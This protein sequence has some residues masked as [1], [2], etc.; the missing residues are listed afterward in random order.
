MFVA[1]KVR[2]GISWV[3]YNKCFSKK[4]QSLSLLEGLV[5]L[6][7]CDSADFI[8]QSHAGQKVKSFGFGRYITL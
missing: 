1:I 2:V 4:L 3:V 8:S 7:Y 5:N 6:F